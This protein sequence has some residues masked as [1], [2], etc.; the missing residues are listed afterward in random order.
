MFFRPGAFAKKVASFAVERHGAFRFHETYGDLTR[1][2]PLLR[3][4]S[5]QTGSEPA[6]WLQTWNVPFLVAYELSGI[7]TVVIDHKR[8]TGLIKVHFQLL[9][10]DVEVRFRLGSQLRSRAARAIEL[11]GKVIS[12]Q[13]DLK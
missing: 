6:L 2:D 8:R 12:V 5:R 1:I 11:K 3:S 13:A 10:G 9:I 4:V 7:M